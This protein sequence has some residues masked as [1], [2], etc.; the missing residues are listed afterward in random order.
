MFG[1]DICGFSTKKVHAIITYKG[2]NL[3]LK[4]EV[5]C[6]TDQLTHVYTLVIKPDNTYKIL[7]DNEEKRTGSLFEDWDFLALRQIPDPEA[8]KVRPCRWYLLIPVLW[9]VLELIALS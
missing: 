2:K 1:P 4:P 9:S 7:I 8:K 5:P 3:L 6:E